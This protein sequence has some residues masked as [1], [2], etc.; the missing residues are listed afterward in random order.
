MGGKGEE[1]GQE[2]QQV[3]GGSLPNWHDFLKECSWL[4]HHVEGMGLRESLRFPTA[5]E[6][7]RERDPLSVIPALLGRST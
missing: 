6:G 7:A 5:S 1:A 3:G 2:E 4:L